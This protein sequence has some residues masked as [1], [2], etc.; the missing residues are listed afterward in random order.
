MLDVY[1][2][3]RKELPEGLDVN[4]AM[5]ARDRKA[6]M[7]RVEFRCMDNK[8][9]YVYLDEEGIT[10]LLK[11]DYPGGQSP[12]KVNAALVKCWAVLDRIQQADCYGIE[13]TIDGYQE[14]ELENATIYSW[15]R[16][17]DW[18]QEIRL[19]DSA[20]TRMFLEGT[21]YQSGDAELG[22]QYQQFSGG[23]QG[24]RG[25]FIPWLASCNWE[26]YTIQVLNDW[27]SRVQL[28]MEA[29]NPDSDSY[30]VRFYFDDQDGLRDLSIATFR[31]GLVVSNQYT[32][33][34]TTDRNTV[35]QRLGTYA[36]LT[37]E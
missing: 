29:K 5:V 10:K 33:I 15:V 11:T 32:T 26:D 8:G 25:Q 18:L 17:G 24:D 23:S 30:Y 6:K 19:K 1:R 20:S 2:L 13:T 22:Q 12:E 31:D 14:Y 37:E 4:R 16:D 28:S 3:A 9:F 21:E 27:G 34:L 35:S 36:I 7:W